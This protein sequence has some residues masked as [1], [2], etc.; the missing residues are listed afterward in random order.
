M[1][2][3]DEMVR[4]ALRNAPKFWR[5]YHS[6]EQHMRAALEAALAAMWRPINEADKDGMRVS[7]KTF[8]LAHAEKKWIRFGKWYVQEG[9]WYYSGTS[10]RSQWAQVRGDAPTHFM[11][12][13]SP[14]KAGGE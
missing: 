1:Q 8:I 10:E 13:P 5:D 6:A 14:P 3:T 7:S 9:C 4:A 11:P 2:I 12:L